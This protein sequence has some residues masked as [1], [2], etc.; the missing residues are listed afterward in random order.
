VSLTL[1][2]GVSAASAYQ[3]ED[4]RIAHWVGSGPHAAVLIVDFWPGNGAADSFAFGCRFATEAI[5]G[6]ELLDA[7]ATAGIGFS[8]I[9]AGAGYITQIAYDDGHTVHTGVDNWP[10]AWLSY[11]FSDDFGGTWAFADTGPAGR[12][13]YD[14]DTDARLVLPGDDYESEPTP[15]LLIRGDLNCSGAVDFADI[16]PFVLALT[17]PAGYAGAFPNCPLS[18]G[19]VNHDGVVGF[20]DINP[21]VAVLVGM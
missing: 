5:T 16:N 20:G 14:G 4:L 7:L 9:D 19:D 13:M 12:I 2:C 6:L 11:W 15:P 1:G 18:T 10:T 8:Y 17:N 3:L 21:F